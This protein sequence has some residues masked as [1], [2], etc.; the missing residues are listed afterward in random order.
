MKLKD[1]AP[2]IVVGLTF[3]SSLAAEQV[4]T[5]EPG[6]SLSA[7]SLRYYRD[8]SHW[9]L[10]WQANPDKVYQNGALILVG[11]QLVIPDPPAQAPRVTTPDHTRVNTA[12]GVQEIDIVTGNDYKPYTDESLPA[13]GM[14]TEVADKAFRYLGYAP[15]IDFVNWPS[16]YDLT[17][18]GKFAATFPYAPTEER[19]QDY[20]YSESIADTLTY[21]YWSNGRA[22]EFRD[23][24]DL[25]GQRVCRPEGYFHDFLDQLINSGQIDFYEPRQLDT[26]FQDVVEGTVDVV[27]IGELDGDAKL[28]EMKLVDQIARSD[29]AANVGSLH[30]IFPKS[31]PNSPA[32]L[33]RFDSVLRDMKSSGEMAEIA[34]RHL[35]AYYASLAPSSS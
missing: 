8:Q 35:K 14:L 15:T 3:G 27:V 1:L 6:D 29:V 18:R 7:I 2:L 13:G 12:T 24:D 23:L 20:L 16:G 25:R 17:R 9:P 30:V 32:L 5:V 34:E 33:E 22:F 19:K 28:V 31:D 11:T 4:Y 10:I 21:V 26:C